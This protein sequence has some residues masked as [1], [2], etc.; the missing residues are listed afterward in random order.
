MCAVMSHNSVRGVASGFLCGSSPRLYNEDLMQ[1][2][3]E[4]GPVLEWTV[5]A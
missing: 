4:L 2:E 5:I 3:L 1:L